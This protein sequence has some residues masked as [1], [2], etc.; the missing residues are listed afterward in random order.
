MRLGAHMSIS[1]G[2]P[3]ALKRGEEIGRQSIQMFIRNVRG[4]SSKPFIQKEID[5][6]L[7]K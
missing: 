7:K 2:N 1:G 6:F 4:W 3:L 5:V